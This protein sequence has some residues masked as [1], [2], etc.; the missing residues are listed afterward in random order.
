MP[1]EWFY[2]VTGQGCEPVSSTELK[3]LA[4]QG[5][6]SYDMLLRKSADGDWIPTDHINGV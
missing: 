5:D 4:Q 3:R 1:T 6:I 2:Q